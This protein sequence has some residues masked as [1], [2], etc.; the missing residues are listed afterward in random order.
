[1]SIDALEGGRE[2]NNMI[3]SSLFYRIADWRRNGRMPNSNS[4]PICGIIIHEL[5]LLFIG[6]LDRKLPLL[7]RRPW[8]SL[9]LG[10][11]WRRIVESR[12]LAPKWGCC[13]YLIKCTIPTWK[14][15][16]SARSGIAKYSATTLAS[17]ARQTEALGNATTITNMRAMQQ[18]SRYHDYWLSML[19]F[20]GQSKIE[21]TNTS[22][23]LPG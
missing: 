2:N 12:V 15:L 4:T 20:K 5:Y 1:M 17:C 13:D 7:R 22:C 19:L 6:L 16:K 8:S 18:Q 21:G 23:R 9:L 11:S 14:S 10:P 3:R